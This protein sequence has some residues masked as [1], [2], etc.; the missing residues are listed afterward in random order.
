MFLSSAKR[1]EAFL[2]L[3]MRGLFAEQDMKIA[4][5]ASEPVLIFHE[6]SDGEIKFADVRT[7]WY[8]CGWEKVLL[9]PRLLT[10]T[11]EEEKSHF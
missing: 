11:S 5:R 4:R 3:I 1:T 2:F 8:G 9:K 10:R 6:G 7:S